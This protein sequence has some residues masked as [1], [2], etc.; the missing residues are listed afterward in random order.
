MQKALDKVLKL[1]WDGNKDKLMDHLDKISTIA[2]ANGVSD[3]NVK[4]TLLFAS[5]NGHIK[6]VLEDKKQAGYTAIEKALKEIYQLDE[7]HMKDEM[8]AMKQNDE[9]SIT[10]WR[11]RL[12]SQAVQCKVTEKKKI[13]DI[14]IEGL[15]D[16]KIKEKLED[17]LVGTSRTQLALEDCAKYAEGFQKNEDKKKTS[18]KSQQADLG[19]AITQD[20]TAAL[21]EGVAALVV[22]SLGHQGRPA[23]EIDCWGCRGLGH[24]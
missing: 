24:P 14:F 23:G 3:D 17:K 10:E 6:R 16:K 1:Q 11:I 8:E 22:A 12:A 2:D 21:I 9:E 13:V 19:A 5:I 15:K 18:V 20:Q 4:G 7:E